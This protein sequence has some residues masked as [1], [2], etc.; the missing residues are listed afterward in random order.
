MHARTA[1]VRYGMRKTYSFSHQKKAPKNK[2]QSEEEASKRKGS[3][4]YHYYRYC[5]LQGC[6]SLVK[7]LPPHLAKVHKLPPDEV[8]RTLSKVVGKRVRDSHRV[9]IH[10]RRLQHSNTF[11]DESDQP[12]VPE[13]G[14]E[15]VPSIVLSDNMSE[16]ES[17]EDEDT[18]ETVSKNV[19]AHEVLKNFK[20]WLQSA[21]GG[22]L[23][24][25]TTQQHFKQM[26]K[27]LSIID[28]KMEVSSLYDHQVINE[29]FLELYAKRLYHPKTTQSY[30]MSLRHF[31][32]FSLATDLGE[33]TSKEKVIALKEKVARWSTSFRR[34]SAKRHWEKK[35]EDFH[36]LISPEQI[37]EFERSKAARDAICLLGKLTG[38][39]NMEIFQRQYTLLRDF[40]IVEISI[41]NASR[42]GALANMKMGEFKKMKTEGDDSVILVK[43]HKTMASHGPARIVLSQKLSRWLQIFVTEVRPRIL[44]A[45]NDN[46]SNVFLSW[47]GERL[48]S[49]QI[50]KAMKSV[51]KKAD[52]D[53]TIH[54]TILRKSAVSGVHSTTDSNETHS[55]LADLMAHNVSTARHY[56]KLNEKSKSS[57]KASRQLRCVMR[58]ENQQKESDPKGLPVVSS[59][60][61]CQSKTSKGSWSPGK[62]TLVRDVFEKEIAQKSVSL[63]IVKS[64]ISKLPE[65]QNESPKRVLDKVRSQWRYEKNTAAEPSDLPSEQE[66]V[67]QR[68][69]RILDDKENSSDVI[70]PTVTSSMKNFFTSAELE[71][72]R[73]TFK[74]MIAKAAPISKPRIKEMLQKESWGR[75]MLEKVSVDTIVNRIKYERRVH[76]SLK[77]IQV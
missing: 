19:H 62:E 37:K 48:A 9:P 18:L 43:D 61:K 51:W 42:S 44:G 54:T 11:Q 47:N 52:I 40:L 41:D 31:Y 45:T 22:Q 17:N 49:S 8:K 39:Q 15:I 55:D 3:K 56:Y 21:D 1:L 50:S 30:L 26:L 72:V 75:D 20:T 58:G 16:E 70:P 28:E 23:D 67:E 38:A 57:V 74:E 63:E 25:K 77:N 76:R 68:V 35:E 46:D 10:E 7:R 69:Q 60:Q 14:S 53:G 32:S 65:L 36:A 59:P 6:T 13:H 71:K 33:S 5:P 24:A 66:S 2:K 27:L 4:D 73:Y 12:S 34:S 64:K 29:K